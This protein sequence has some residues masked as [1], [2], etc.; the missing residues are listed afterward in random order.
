MKMLIAF[1]IVRIV[2][3]IIKM[4]KG[5]VTIKSGMQS[6]FSVVGALGIE[7][8]QLLL[9]KSYQDQQKLLNIVKKAFVDVNP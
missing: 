1:I 5:T 8:I 9:F 4:V 7:Y 3:S 6:G 2:I